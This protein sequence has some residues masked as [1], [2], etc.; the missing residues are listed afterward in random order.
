MM[1]S[2]YFS[3][4]LLR[5]FCSELIELGS[6]TGLGQHRKLKGL[7]RCSVCPVTFESRSESSTFKGAI[8][9]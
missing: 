4:L 2:W 6:E 1:I 5:G 7:S 8:V 3:E 9:L